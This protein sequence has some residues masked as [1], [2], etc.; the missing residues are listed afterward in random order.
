MAM[1]ITIILTIVFIV[2]ITTLWIVLLGYMENREKDELW[3]ERFY[4]Y[5]EN[6]GKELAE[7]RNRRDKE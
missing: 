3:I 7:R 6:I 1:L 2:V 5:V 4:D